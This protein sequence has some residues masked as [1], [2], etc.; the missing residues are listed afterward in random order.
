MKEDFRKQ[1]RLLSG[2]LF[3]FVIL[4]VTISG[5]FLYFAKHP[6]KL[7]FK[8]TPETQTIVIGESDTKSFEN[9]VHVA[10][11]FVVDE[12]MELVIQNCTNCHSAKLVT[13]NRMSA[14]GWQATIQWMQETQNFWDLGK[15]E[16]K[17]IAYLAKNYG[18][19]VKGRRLNLTDVEW[20]QLE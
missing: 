5:M 1:I 14:D 3:S 19:A 4:L 9:G 6:E 7:S 2:M 17:I 20:Y 11:G 13:Q 16:E 18:P 15:N 8:G 12:G 10:T